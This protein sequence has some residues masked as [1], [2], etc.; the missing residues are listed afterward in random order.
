MN[1]KTSR[2]SS[3]ALK[4]YLHKYVEKFVVLFIMFKDNL[5]VCA[6]KHNNL[7]LLNAKVN[8]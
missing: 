8:K 5:C 4:S 1:V 6:N 3:Y 7:R 2:V